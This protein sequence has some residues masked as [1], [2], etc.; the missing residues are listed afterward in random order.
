MPAP[1]PVVDMTALPVALTARETVLLEGRPHRGGDHK[2]ARYADRPAVRFVQRLP[3]GAYGVLVEKGR[4]GG[5][6]TR[7]RSG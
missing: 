2:G 1:L 5:L 4:R 7:S 6:T 3:R